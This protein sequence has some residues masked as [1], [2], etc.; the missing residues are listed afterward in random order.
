MPT[1]YNAIHRLRLLSDHSCSYVPL[2]IYEM[3]NWNC[4]F[5]SFLFRKVCAIINSTNFDT[6]D[7]KLFSKRGGIVFYKYEE[8]VNLARKLRYTNLTPL[9]EEAFRNARCYDPAARLF[10]I[11]NTS[12]G[13]TL[14]PLLL[15]FSRR[16][17]GE[18][19]KMLF[20]VPYRSLAAQKFLEISE[21]AETLGL[22]LRIEQCTGEFRSADSDVRQGDVDIAVIIYEKV[23][24]FSGMDSSF[25][26]KY[27]FLVMDEV[28]LTQDVHRGIKAD[29]ILARAQACDHMSIVLLGTPFYNWENYIHSY[30]FTRICYEKRPVE[31]KLFPIYCTR[32]GINH[33]E[34]ECEA[35][36][37]REARPFHNVESELNK[38]QWRDQIVEDIC[39]FH[40]LQNQKILIFENNREEV[41]R[42][43][44]RLTR[45]LSKEGYLTQHTSI[46]DCKSLIC[47][48]MD[49]TEKDSETILFHI[50]EQED[51]EAF[52]H[53][54]SY[55]NASLPNPLRTLIEQEILSAGGCLQIVCSTETLAYGINS[56][57]DVVIIPDMM[58]QRADEEIQNSFL[59]ANEYMNYAGRAG[60]LHKE[61]PQKIQPPGYVYPLIRADYSSKEKNALL[62]GPDQIK[63]WEQMLY[64]SQHPKQIESLY[65][66]PNQKCRPLYLLSLFPHLPGSNSH[67]ISL[68]ELETAIRRLP[69]SDSSVFNREEHLMRP[70]QYLLEKQFIS[71]KESDD[72]LDDPYDKEDPL[73]SEYRLT[74]IGA[75]LAGYII[76]TDDLDAI[77][78]TACACIGD[79]YLYTIE[80]VMKIL[81]GDEICGEVMNAATS[82]KSVPLP[83]K[84]SML[85]YICRQLQKNRNLIS[86]EKQ[87]ELQKLTGILWE[88]DDVDSTDIHI[89]SL[90]RNH[91]LLRIVGAILIWTDPMF[92]PKQLYKVFRITE[93]QLLKV[94]EKISYH[95]DIV[96]LVLPSFAIQAG[97]WL[98]EERMAE[99]QAQLA[100]ISKAYNYQ[101]SPQICKEYEI[102]ATSPEN[103][104][105]I[106]RLARLHVYLSQ[107]DRMLNSHK[108]LP[109]KE[110]HL[111]RKRRKNI[112]SLPDDLREKIYLRFERVLSNGD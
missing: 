1:I 40:L 96:R 70:L 56:N 83:D 49:I 79:D 74:D 112:D 28:G 38:I 17:N 21:I 11:G 15:F 13:K 98:G 90:Y 42:R 68:E 67:F 46:E 86:P 35:V 102:D 48:A 10:V 16:M 9:Q 5:F 94:A 78:E 43:A 30:N 109:K 106:K 12:S 77:M 39:R 50:M 111:L 99:I 27:D 63:E 62:K 36:S 72:D 55:H 52:S 8:M 3:F 7:T 103:V 51:Y 84:E 54:I 66:S 92:T 18:N 47:K 85:I 60:R 108:V 89:H 65:F 2:H 29:F 107:L 88:G 73:L 71:A 101:V 22:K 81:E 75:A 6:I 97:V 105:L 93:Q 25:L 58:K 32:E 53:G 4:K 14:V 37:C 33:I 41:R 80:L 20:A 110:R 87:Q 82:L 91:H 76:Q 95:L 34:P 59:R 31:L 44:Q 45:V 19:L 23:F 57:V 100:D 61:N 64:D 104:K 69:V 24:M 26:E